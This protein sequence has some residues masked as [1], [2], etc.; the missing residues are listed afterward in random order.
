LNPVH[1]L[2]SRFFKIYFNI[3]LVDLGACSLFM[4]FLFATFIPMYSKSAKF[5]SICYASF[6]QSKQA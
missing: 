5:G 1:S 6:V 3:I 4:S 2:I